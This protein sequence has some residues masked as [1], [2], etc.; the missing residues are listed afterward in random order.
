MELKEW[1]VEEGDLTISYERIVCP[2][3]GWQLEGA[4]E[5]HNEEDKET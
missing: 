1:Y 3:C 2:H 4:M 5:F